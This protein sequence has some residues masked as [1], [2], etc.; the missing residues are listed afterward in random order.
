MIG[1]GEKVIYK[2]FGLKII[3]DIPLPELQITNNQRDQIDVFIEIKDLSKRWEQLI[4]VSQTYL[5]KENLVLFRIYDTAIFSI[6]NGNRIVVSPVN[7]FNEDKI[8]LFILGTCMGALLIQREIVPLHGSAIEI[9]GKA[10]AVIGESGAGKS[11][12]ASAFLSQGYKLLSDDV[13]AVT[14]S[15]NQTPFVIPAYPQQKLWQT[16]LDQFEMEA[17]N[18]RPIIEREAKYAIPVS[19]KFSSEVLPLAGVFELCITEN[20]N[21]EIKKINGLEQLHIL[22]QHTYRNFLIELLDLMEWHFT[23]STQ[24]IKSV[25][26]FRVNRPASRFTAHELV[27][28]ILNTIQKEKS[29]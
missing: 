25:D 8:R 7:G 5:V 3:S 21:V 17:S 2:A 15:Q 4:P 18:F 11:T 12:L 22:F 14:F 13:I 29:K 9:D 6:E 23:T 24:L 27:S 28:L 19:T 20:E 16:S 26:V 1:V 10:Y